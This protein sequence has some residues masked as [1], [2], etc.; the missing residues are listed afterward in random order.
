L[1]IYEQLSGVIKS[2]ILLE[3]NQEPDLPHQHLLY[4]ELLNTHAS[5]YR[6]F[7]EERELKHSETILRPIADGLT[8]HFVEEVAARLRVMLLVGY[9]QQR[10]NSSEMEKCLERMAEC[11]WQEAGAGVA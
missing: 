7:T 6:P 1:K 2:P 11:G 9:L 8:R 5:L 4:Q 10:F 3:G